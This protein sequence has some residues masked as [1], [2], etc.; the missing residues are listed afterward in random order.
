ML[1]GISTPTVSIY[2]F[3]NILSILFILLF[4]DCGKKDK[5]EK[6][7]AKA[8]FEMVP[9]SLTK[10]QTVIFAL[11][12]V[13]HYKKAEVS[14][15]VLGRV[16]KIFKEEGAKVSKGTPLAKIE[17]LNLEIQLKKDMASFEVQNKQIELT[18]ARYIQSK[19]RV[20]KELTNIEKAS[21]DL[22]DSK[23]T[24]DNLNRT[25]QNKLELF[26][27]GAVSESELKGLETGLVSAQTN[28]FKAQK[29]LDTLMVGYRPEDLQRAGMKV[30]S[31][32][33]QLKDALVDLNT[34]VEKSELDIAVANLKNIQASID[35]TKLLIHESTILSPLKG[36]VAVRSIFPGEAV[37]ESQALFVV[38][39]DSE[40]LLKYSINET[41]L[42]RIKEG[43]EVDFTVDAFPK[44]IFK[45]KVLI[46]SP[47]VDPQSRAS[48]VKILYQN[49]KNELKPGMFARAEIKDLNPQ[50]AFY[51]PAKSI[52][53]GK[54]KDQ[55]YIFSA[56]NGLL[57]KKQIKIEGVSG[58]KSR[59]SGDL[60]EGELIAIGNVGGI[61][62]GEPVPEATPSSS[63]TS[64]SK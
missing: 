1:R 56:K 52:L 38:V 4:I 41:D 16:E 11:G 40:L 49:D 33:S 50:P 10:E 63:S 57:F 25:Y 55:G 18:R 5:T 24:Y 62:E 37:K 7:S 9:L 2:K 27:I 58:E 53:P 31:D 35:A 51:V 36:I 54:E 20:E 23:A 12:S 3:L 45:G 46:I 15:K 61:K 43:Q 6:E 13:S 44:R 19:Q 59:I 28:Y 21:A 32:K 14:S 26:K 39:D 30:P 22:K 34:I 48:E 17:T 42:G 29:N 60:F 47:L 64:T 8:P